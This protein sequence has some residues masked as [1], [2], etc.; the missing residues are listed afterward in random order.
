MEKKMCITPEEIRTEIQ[1]ACNI[2]KEELAQAKI[3]R[4]KDI[5]A[6]IVKD[7]ELEKKLDK[8]IS[9]ILKNQ[10]SYL[11][12]IEGL[13]SKMD[14]I[15]PRVSEDLKEKE[16]IDYVANRWAK[17]LRTSSFWAGILLKV[18]LFIT[19]VVSIYTLVRDLIKGVI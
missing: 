7:K 15:F 1:E 16:A 2:W 11:K 18:I 13:D 10:T 12:A 19:I 5:D 14:L 6:L 4:Q 8:N 9:D 3:D 17:K